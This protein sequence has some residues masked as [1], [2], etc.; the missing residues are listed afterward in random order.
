VRAGSDGRLFAVGLVLA[1]GTSIQ[2]GAA[3][4]VTLFEEVG[5]GG[6]VFL[7]LLFAAA[8][9]LVVWRPSV[10]GQEP[11]SLRVALLF[12]L[13]LGAMNWTFYEALDRIPLGVCVTLE[14]IGPLSVAVL[15]SRRPRDL[16][17]VGLAAFGVLL[18]A[19][20]S[21]SDLDL[22]GVL[23]AFVA[24]TLWGCY[25]LLSARTGRLFSGG[26]GLAL[27]MV[28]A[29]AVTLPAGIAQGGSE[30]LSPG[31][32]AAGALVALAC[33]VVPYSLEMEALRRLPEGVFGVMMS[34][35]PGLAAMSGYLILDQDLKTVDFVAIVLVIAASAGAALTT[36]AP[37]H[38][39]V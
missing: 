24:G 12:G 26:H 39:E 20:P 29:A 16:A 19:N 21:T 25:I 38:V 23:L 6:A 4:A 30:L 15:G 33:S 3:F 7:R 36:R 22:V 1:A 27:A 31:M 8:M 9:L 18:L 14:M 10:R 5:P 35:E 2:L 32:L 13:V 34:L 17:W 11:G 28:A 37:A